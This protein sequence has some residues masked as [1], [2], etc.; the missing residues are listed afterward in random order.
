VLLEGVPASARV[1]LRASCLAVLLG[2]VTLSWS[3]T[4]L[5]YSGDFTQDDDQRLVNFTI[6]APATV[7]LQSWSYGGGVDP[8]ANVISAGGFGPVLSIFDSTGNLVGFDRGGTVG[9]LPPNDCGTGG[10]TVDAVSGFC[11]DAYL[12][13][14][15]ASVGE[16]TVVLTQQDNTPNGPTLADGFAFDGAGNFTGGFIDAGGF[17]RNSSYYFTI[18]LPDSTVVPEP[19]TGFLTLAALCLGA[20][21]NVRKRLQRRKVRSE[22]R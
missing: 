3:A 22:H 14:P 7:T 9:G 12:E 4:I 15:L 20:A 17:Q 5:S 13:I 16:Y 11:L 6:L 19:A 21:A 10:R 18:S 1:A 2:S 8:L